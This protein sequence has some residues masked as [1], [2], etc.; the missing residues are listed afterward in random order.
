MEHNNITQLMLKAIMGIMVCNRR[1]G[2]NEHPEMVEYIDN[3]P[4]LKTIPHHE[5][6][7]IAYKLSPNPDSE[8]SHHA[9]ILESFVDLSKHLPQDS[10]L[11]KQIN[12]YQKQPWTAS[13][14]DLRI[15][16]EKIYDCVKNK[17]C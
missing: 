15:V 14:R 8:Y 17:K 11:V 10:N 4:D 1:N 2:I 16:S 6:A 9:D 12:Q 3:Y 5:V 7:Y 13:F